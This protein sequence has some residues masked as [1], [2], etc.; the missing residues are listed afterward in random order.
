MLF[1]IDII[2]TANGVLTLIGTLMMPDS[3]EREQ[4]L[5]PT[6]NGTTMR[7][8]HAGFGKSKVGKLGRRRR[9]TGH[10]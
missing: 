1:R 6:I 4:G 3:L 7:A 10:A 5:V 8:P 9:R 2:N